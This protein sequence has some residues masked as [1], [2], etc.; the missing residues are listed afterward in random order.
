MKPKRQGDYEM[1]LFTAEI[2]AR[3]MENGRKNAERTADEGSVIDFEP[4]V[5]LFTPDA[6]CTGLLTEID[7]EDA[8]IAFGL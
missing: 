5:K 2:V 7:P 1:R 3:R 6:G 8:D 4:V